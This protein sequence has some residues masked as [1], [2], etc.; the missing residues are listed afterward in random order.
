MQAARRHV[1]ERGD[2]RKIGASRAIA[3]QSMDTPT[4]ALARC[5]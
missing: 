3:R 5:R 1:G 2:A 4:A